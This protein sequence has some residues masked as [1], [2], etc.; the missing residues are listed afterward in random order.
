MVNILVIA[1]EYPPLKTIGRIRSA[2]F[3]QHWQ[4]A[5]HNPVVLTLHYDKTEPHYEDSLQD[6][7]PAGIKVYRVKNSKRE[8]SLLNLIKSLRR[9]K[10]AKPKPEPSHS[11]NSNTAAK[12]A[13]L[14]LKDRLINGYKSLFRHWLD[15]PDDFVVWAKDCLPQALELIK[16][17]NIDVIYT[18]LPPFSAC[19][20]GYQ[21]KQQT[22]LPWVVDYRDLWTGDVLREWIHPLRSRFETHLER[23]YVRHADVVVTV[24]QQKT[25]FVKALLNQPHQ[26]YHTITNGYDPESFNYLAP[27]AKTNTALFNIVYCGRLFK[28]RKG[29]AFL[30]ALGQLSMQQPQ[31]TQQ[32]KLHF[33]GDIAPEINAEYDKLIAQYQLQQQVI[34]HGDVSF[35]QAKQAQVD[36]D[37]LLLIVDTG[38][39]SDGVIP[40]KLFEYIACNKPIFALS[41][42]TATNEILIQGKLGP[43]VSPDDIAGCK[44]ALATLLCSP[45]AAPEIN[46]TYLQQFKREAKAN[47]MV[48]IFLNATKKCS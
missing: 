10:A 28:N 5:G 44:N 42:A 15:I 14:S 23:K 3:V 22:G 31:L 43:V 20:L 7:I 2:K 45:S 48:Q 16:Q 13:N 38:A 39:T 12:P 36:A 6:E 29:Y 41:D 26:Q 17:H 9:T 33:Y 32:V 18:S 1:G 40:G 19:K 4:N 25:D 21:L 8:D 47:D 37:M 30:H 24:S 35:E 27:S 34:R 46:H 11:I